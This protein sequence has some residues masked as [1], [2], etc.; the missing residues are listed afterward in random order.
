MQRRVINPWTWQD[1]FDFSQAV[2]TR[3]AERVVYVAG[4]VSVDELGRPLHEGDMVA[5]F[6]KALDNLE[7][8]L[9]AAGLT[10]ADVVRLDYYVTDVPAFLEAVP[11]VGPRLERRAASRPRRSSASRGS[12]S[13]D[14]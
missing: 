14:T 3:A 2:E 9:A 5:Q 13:R 11:L 7:Q 6:G 1:E 4:Q 8:V 12:L 10:L